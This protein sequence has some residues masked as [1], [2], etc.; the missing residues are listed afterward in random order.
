MGNRTETI[1]FLVSESEKQDFEEYIENNPEYDSLSRFFR[2]LGHRELE[3]ASDVE[4]DQ[5]A[6]VDAVDVGVSDLREEIVTLS[7]QIDDIGAE[8]DSSDEIDKIARDLYGVLPQVSEEEFKAKSFDEIVHNYDVDSLSGI[9]RVST[10]SVWARYLDISV[11]KC[12]RGLVRCDEYFADV[13]F[14]E[15]EFEGESGEMASLPERRWFR[16]KE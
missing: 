1:K 15:E 13:K 10:A 5:N 16:Q 12:R 9:K 3:G 2:V 6:I 7:K 8:V 14:L 11:P 4:I